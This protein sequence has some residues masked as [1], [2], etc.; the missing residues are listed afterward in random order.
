MRTNQTN[1]PEFQMYFT[2][3]DT[4]PYSLNNPIVIPLDY[5]MYISVS[6]FVVDSS[7]FYASAGKNTLL[8]YNSTTT[9]FTTITISTATYTPIQLVLALTTAFNTAGLSTI[10]V[11]WIKDHFL[12]TTP[13]NIT[14]QISQL[15][16]AMGLPTGTSPYNGSSSTVFSPLSD[17][18]VSTNLS[19]RNLTGKNEGCIAKYPFPSSCSSYHNYNAFSVQVYE[20]VINEIE[21]RFEDKFGTKKTFMPSY[22]LTLQ[23]DICEPSD[24]LL[25][26]PPDSALNSERSSYI[27]S[28]ADSSDNILSTGGEGDPTPENMPDPIG[29]VPVQSSTNHLETDL[30]VVP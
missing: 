6:D 13:S 15:A 17:I 9:Q 23:F 16:T 18:Y 30:Y 25:P 20:K 14:L 22:S 3:V 8:F 12:L 28:L 29:D 1:F 2:D 7:S 21:I 27:G 26:R 5:L 11:D 24:R 19:V 4:F 10:V